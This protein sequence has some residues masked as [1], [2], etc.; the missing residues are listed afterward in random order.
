MRTPKQMSVPR[1]VFV[2]NEGTVSLLPA[3]RACANVDR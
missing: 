2:R 3:H 1:D